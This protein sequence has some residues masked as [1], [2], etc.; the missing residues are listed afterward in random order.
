[1]AWT[2]FTT[3]IAPGGVITIDQ[4]LELKSAIHER[5]QAVDASWGIG[6]VDE[7][8]QNDG[9][10]TRT[11]IITTKVRYTGPASASSVYGTADTVTDEVAH[12]LDVLMRVCR[13]FIVPDPVEGETSGYSFFTGPYPADVVGGTSLIATALANLGLSPYLIG[14]GANPVYPFTMPLSRALEWNLTREAVRLLRWRRLGGQSYDPAYSTSYEQDS[15]LTSGA[16]S[17]AIT[18][19]TGA[20]EYPYVGGSQ[21]SV[22]MRVDSNLPEEASVGSTHRRDKIAGVTI[23]N[24]SVWHTWTAAV[25]LAADVVPGGG[26][27]ANYVQLGVE[28]EIHGGTALTCIT[29]ATATTQWRVLFGSATY[30]GGAITDFHMR[31]KDSDTASSGGGSVGDVFNV[32]LSQAPPPVG[33]LTGASCRVT[34]ELAGKPNFVYD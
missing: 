8:A 27:Y 3:P 24:T 2:Y 6:N 9:M 32:M 33:G 31:F 4:W 21:A 23:P 15:G 29:P 25:S 18:A 28:V 34:A 14:A 11:G 30:Y 26:G 16:L 20:T 13:F 17:A 19:Y 7:F 1:M 5:L 12:M 10:G 22:R